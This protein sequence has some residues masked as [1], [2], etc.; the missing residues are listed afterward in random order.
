[1]YV[2]AFT[3]ENH[4]VYKMRI[5][6]EF[7]TIPDAAS[8]FAAEQEVARNADWIRSAAELSAVKKKDSRA[9]NRFDEI[10]RGMP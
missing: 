1:M 2:Q 8:F 9:K 10:R 4:E 7:L 6:S 3:P 5:F